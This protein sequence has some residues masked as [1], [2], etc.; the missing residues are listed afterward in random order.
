MNSIRTLKSHINFINKNIIFF[1]VKF[2]E[3]IFYLLNV[4]KIKNKQKIINHFKSQFFVLFL[5]INIC[6]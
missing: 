1:S 5:N 3:T 2:T 4:L 6:N